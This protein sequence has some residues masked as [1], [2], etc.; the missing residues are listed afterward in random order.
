LLFGFPAKAQ[1]PPPQQDLQSTIRE[2]VEQAR[3]LR[4]TQESLASALAARKA[5]REILASQIATT[6]R[7]WQSVRDLIDKIDEQYESFS[8]SHQSAVREAWSL[9]KI[10]GV[11]VE[12]LKT[13]AAKP[14]SPERDK[15]LISNV[16][17]TT[18]RATML[19]ETLSQ[20]V[21]P[22]RPPRP[23]SL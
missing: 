11:F 9:A 14:D 22:A 15:E 7:T 20:L 5:S 2:A 12:Y 13:T 16:T 18:R 19:E 17:S 3:S 21:T 6:E 1:T 4:K 23:R 8:E 10:F